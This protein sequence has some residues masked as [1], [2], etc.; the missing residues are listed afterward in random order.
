MRARIVSTVV[1]VMLFGPSIAFAQSPVEITQEIIKQLKETQ[2]MD[3]A[4]EHIDWEGAYEQLPEE[5]KKVMK[6]KSAEDVKESE[7]RNFQSDGPDALDALNKALAAATGDER[8]RLESMKDR[9]TESLAR[10]EADNRTA[11]IR[12]GYKIGKSSIDGDKATV[13]L[14]KTLEGGKK[15]FDNLEFR[16]ING[17]WKL[18]SAAAFNPAPGWG[19][20][21]GSSSVLG[22]P[23]ADPSEGVA[24]IF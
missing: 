5:Q 3:A 20:K 12:I 1:V 4:I 11:F 15:E 22:P 23:I 18:K 16:K 2:T 6:L 19:G 14:I 21:T 24:R 8:K 17:S 9:L 10:Q 7:L 13:E